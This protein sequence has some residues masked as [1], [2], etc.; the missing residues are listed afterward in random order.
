MI[1]DIPGFVLMIVAIV[2]C[3][4]SSLLSFKADKEHYERFEELLKKEKEYND[5]QSQIRK[6]TIKECDSCNKDL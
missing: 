3:F 2:L 5:L 4:N 1:F 6:T